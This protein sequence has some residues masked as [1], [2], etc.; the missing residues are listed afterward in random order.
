MRLFLVLTMFLVGSFAGA[1]DDTVSG[2]WIYKMDTPQGEV[3]AALTL[4]ADN[5][6]VS[7]KFVFDGNRVLEITEGTFEGDTLKLTVKRNRQDGGSMTYKM[8]GKVEGKSI[9]GTSTAVEMSEA[10]EMTWSATRN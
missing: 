4:K 7:G 10:G 2:E 8:T 9:K 3:T 6:K 5:G 1:A